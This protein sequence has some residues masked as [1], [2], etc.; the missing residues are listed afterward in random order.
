MSDRETPG[1]AAAAESARQAVALVFMLASVP[2]FVWVQRKL[3]DPDIWRTERMRA[4][5]AAGIRFDRAAAWCLR[6]A[7]R[8]NAAYERER[9]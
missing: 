3:G 2:L 1:Q 8:C 6:Q 9:P 5:R 7:D 4:A